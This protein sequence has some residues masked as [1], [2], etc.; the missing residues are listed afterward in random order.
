MR[1]FIDSV[2]KLFEQ[3]DFDHD[4]WS[5]EVD[6]DFEEKVYPARIAATPSNIARAKDFVMR[7]W[8]E[9][10]HERFHNVAA[11]KNDV[12]TDL[13][14][15]CKFTSLFAREIFGGR[16]RGNHDHQFVELPGGQI[17]DLN[18]EASDVRR[19]GAEAHEHDDELFWGNPEHKDSVESCKPRALAWAKEFMAGQ[20]PGRRTS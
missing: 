17:L 13:T 19:L 9:R 1:K 3:D 6:P 15:S 14:D 10:H 18:I 16:L 8:I 2:Q 11:F 12:P 7:K 4:G 20:K 5:D